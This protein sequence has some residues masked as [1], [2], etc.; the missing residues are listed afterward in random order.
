MQDLLPEVPSPTRGFIRRI[1][2]LNRDLHISQLGCIGVQ[3]VRF[4]PKP[5]SRSTR[6]RDFACFDRAMRSLFYAHPMSPLST[7]YVLLNT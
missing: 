4:G 6:Q 5:I 1:L 7:A 3:T 2:F